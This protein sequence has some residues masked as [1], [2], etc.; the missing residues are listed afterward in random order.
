MFTRTIF[1]PPSYTVKLQS[2]NPIASH[3]EIFYPYQSNHDKYAPNDIFNSNF[4]KET[5][6]L[7]SLFKNP[8]YSLRPFVTKTKNVKKFQ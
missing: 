7:F 4:C 6:G 1:Y 3:C 8:T 2:K 5:S